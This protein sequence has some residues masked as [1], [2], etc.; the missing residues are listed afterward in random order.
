MRKTVFIVFWIM[1]FSASTI[2]AQEHSL[3][4]AI[5]AITRTVD[6][7]VGVAVMDLESRDTLTV[8]GKNRYPMQSV[9]KFPLALAVLDQVDRGKLSLEQKIHLSKEE[10]IPNTWSP[11]AKKYPEGNVDVPLREVL[12]GVVSEG[13]NN[14]C[15]MLFRLIGGPKKAE[16]Y[17]YSIGVKDLTIVNTEGEMHKS[18]DV[19]YANW[20]NPM[21]MVNLLALAFGNDILSPS[22]KALLHTFMKET[23]TGQ[24][25]IKG[26]LPAETVVFHRTGGSGTNDAGITAAINNVG[27][28]VLPNGQRVAIAVFVSNTSASVAA[29]ENVIARISKAV[30]DHYTG[31]SK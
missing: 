1:L 14:A 10:M 13:D 2:T 22:S 16:E 5:E 27:V 6:G 12:R 25:R 21:A 26:L 23:I 28:M 9:Y 24:K 17:V 11:L 8:N 30:Y 3:R 7:R 15:D 20:S 31:S 4:P 18:W 29:A 19:Q